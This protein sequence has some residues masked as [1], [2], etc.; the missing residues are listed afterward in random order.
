MDCKPQDGGKR[1]FPRE[2]YASVEAPVPRLG[3]KR[4]KMKEF[5]A[6][7]DRGRQ[8]RRELGKGDREPVAT[9]AEGG[10]GSEAGELANQARQS[11]EMQSDKKTF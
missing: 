1:S 2:Q 8:R 11:C 10:L 3:F 9:K 5:S 4:G 6:E 7:D